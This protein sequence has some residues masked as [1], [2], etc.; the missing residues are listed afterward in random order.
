VDKPAFEIGDIVKLEY[1]S[2]TR[3]L[4]HSYYRVTAWSSETG[5][6]KYEYL[7]GFFNDK[8]PHEAW[9]NLRLATTSELVLLQLA[10]RI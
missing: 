2:D 6:I 1:N 7:E 8:A 10:G 9:A 3:G 5:A 4:I